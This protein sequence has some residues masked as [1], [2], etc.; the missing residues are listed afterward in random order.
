MAS[1]KKAALN[2]SNRRPGYPF[3]GAAPDNHS[4]Q[5]A[6]DNMQTYL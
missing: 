2:P 6:K 1:L 5:K 3:A 4:R